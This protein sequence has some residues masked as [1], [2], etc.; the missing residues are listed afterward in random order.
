MSLCSI[1]LMTPNTAMRRSIKDYLAPNHQLYGGDT[2]FVVF[3]SFPPIK[4][5]KDAKFREW[6]ASTNEKFSNHKGFIRRRL[7][8]PLETGNYAAIVE[9]ENQDDFEALH[10]SSEHEQSGRACKTTIRRKSHT[11]FLRSDYRV[12]L[13]FM[14]SGF[15]AW[16]SDL[17]ILLFLLKNNVA[18]LSA[19]KPFY[20]GFVPIRSVPLP[21]RR[22]KRHRGGD[23]PQ[24]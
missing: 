14:A 6:F 18:T 19:L 8:R 21:A 13:R 10:N 2:M 3:I 4:E 5:G 16:L 23:A 15:S 17:S 1:A 24:S 12:G 7:L 9:F 22:T 11:P 20:S